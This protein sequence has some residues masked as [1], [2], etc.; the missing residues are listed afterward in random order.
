MTAPSYSFWHRLGCAWRGCR[1]AFREERHV[2]VHLLVLAL[3][4]TAGLWVGLTPGEWVAICGVSGLVIALELVN[5]ALE[6]TI[7]LLHP[8]HHPL[9]GQVKDIGA[10]AVLVAAIAAVLTGCGVFGPYLVRA[11]LG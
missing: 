6:R 10:G 5:A 4:G 1:V 11:W 3:V 2:R 7:D 8:E 9:A